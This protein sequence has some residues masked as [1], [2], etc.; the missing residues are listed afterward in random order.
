VTVMEA[1]NEIRRVGTVLSAGDCLKVQLPEGAIAELK[2][3]IDTLRE[4]KAQAMA[5]LANPEFS[6]AARAATV[7][8]RAGVRIMALDRGLTI[9]V[10]SD[11]S[12]PEIR[13]ALQVLQLDQLPMAFLEGPGIPLRY[14]V[15]RRDLDAEAR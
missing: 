14:K 9:G 5:I 7:L 8:N 11:L 6:E 15:R 2:P 1:L 3:A 12:G 4:C 10:W 13:A